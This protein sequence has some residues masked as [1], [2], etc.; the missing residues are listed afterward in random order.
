MCMI[1][2]LCVSIN[3]HGMLNKNYFTS[4]PKKNCVKE[5][6]AKDSVTLPWNT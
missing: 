2:L 1:K 6:L 3:K 4:G 5:L